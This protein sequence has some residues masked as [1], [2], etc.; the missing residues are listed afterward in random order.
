MRYS[1][2]HSF[3]IADRYGAFSHG[4]GVCWSIYLGLFEQTES[5][6]VL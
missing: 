6:G 4:N 1:Q 2:L 3:T 5:L